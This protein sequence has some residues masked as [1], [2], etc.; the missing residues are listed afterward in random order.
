[1]R[2]VARNLT[3]SVAGPLCAKAYL[4]R[5]RDPLFAEQFIETLA[6][7][8]VKAVR[9]P[10]RSPNLTAYAERFVR[11]IKES[12]L[13]R[14]IL[15]G[16]RSLKRAT[17]EFI[18]HYHHE[19]NHQGLDNR[20][21]VPLPHADGHRSRVRRRQR[22]GGLLPA[23]SVTGILPLSSVLS[24]KGPFSG[25]AGVRPVRPS[26]TTEVSSL[27]PLNCPQA[28]LASLSRYPERSFEFRNTTPIGRLGRR[29]TSQVSKRPHLVK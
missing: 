3:D 12:C 14:M 16:E 25:P 22:V 7:A 6:G 9:L 1:M 28:I 24:L 17:R 2:Q 21:I 11:T 27:E 26:F 23:G 20:L 29:R 8:G 19:R 15:F 13:D 4:I 18:L 5:D 10:A